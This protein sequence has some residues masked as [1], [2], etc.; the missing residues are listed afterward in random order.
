MRIK[1]LDSTVLFSS[2]FL[3]MPLLATA[4]LTE[5]QKE[6][7]QKAAPKTAQCKPEETRLLLIWNTP[8]MDESPHKGYSIPQS[9]YAM[10]LLGEKTGAF[11]SV[12]SD[13]QTM[14]L[15]KNLKK[16][17]AILFNNA[18]GKW[19]RPTDET[20]KKMKE[21]GEDKDAVEKFLRKSLLDYVSNG[22]GIVAFHHAIGGNT[23]WPEFQELIGAGYW[24]HPWN[25]E[26]GV[27]LEEPD[28]PLL[29]TF[30][31]KDFRIAEEIFQFREPYSRD[32]VRV[33][34][35]LDTEKTNMEVQWIHRKDNDFALAWVK[36]Y[37]EGRVFYSAFGHRTE[38]WWNPNI[39][40]FYLAGIQF[41][42]GDL[43]APIE[44]RS[45]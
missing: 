44:P 5:Q 32:K 2:I 15:P 39:L 20:M 30:D 12:V 7:I 14:F 21:Y 17:D 27:K 45:N 1:Q 11:K 41:A 19:I 28:H 8:F 23:H 29:K 6:R 33:L 16:F 40:R 42:M 35:S 26:V 18:N 36:R 43:E 38:I 24:G 31:G 10:Q 13:D 22:G 37:G 34:L 4:Q 3:L 9:E 25:E